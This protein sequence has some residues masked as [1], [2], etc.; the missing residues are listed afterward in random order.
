MKVDRHYDATRSIGSDIRRLLLVRGVAHAWE[1]QSD[2]GKLLEVLV[3][4]GSCSGHAGLAESEHFNADHSVCPHDLD[5]LTFAS[6]RSL[7][8]ML[9]CR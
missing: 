1:A 5:Q 7:L 6:L 3:P 2:I 8:A 4:V 9:F